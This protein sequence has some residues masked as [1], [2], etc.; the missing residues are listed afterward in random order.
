M[1]ALDPT[2][3]YEMTFLDWG[4]KGCPSGAET[5]LLGLLSGFRKSCCMLGTVF[6]SSRLRERMQLGLL[7]FFIS[8]LVYSY[9]HGSCRYGCYAGTITTISLTKQSDGRVTPVVVVG[10]LGLGGS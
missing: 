3:W 4:V 9:S 7:D 2:G 5:W 8:V 1:A 6:L 10:C